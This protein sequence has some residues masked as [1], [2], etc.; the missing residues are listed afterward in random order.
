[1]FSNGRIDFKDYDYKVRSLISIMTVTVKTLIAV[2]KAIVEDDINSNVAFHMKADY[3][4]KPKYA[5]PIWVQHAPDA[6]SLIIKYGL[7]TATM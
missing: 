4:G 1:M 6:K 7:I 5:V 3:D 2:N